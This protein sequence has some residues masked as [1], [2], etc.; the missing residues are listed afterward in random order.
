MVAL[1]CIQTD[2][3]VQFHPYAQL[4]EDSDFD[5]R[6]RARC[7]GE[8]SIKCNRFSVRAERSGSAD[9][10]AR[11][12]GPFS[13]ALVNQLIKRDFDPKATRSIRLARGPT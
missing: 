5:E 11:T 2:V 8:S 9:G 7:G 3:R 12:M 10:A 13:H 4:A 1:C 6:V